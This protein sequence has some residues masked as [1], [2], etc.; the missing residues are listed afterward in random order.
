MRRRSRFDRYLSFPPV[1]TQALLDI[2]HIKKK[3]NILSIS[4]NGY[5][6]GV[7]Y[8]RLRD[9][10][11]PARELQEVGPTNVRTGPDPAKRDDLLYFS[12]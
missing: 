1:R 8:D 2:A 11:G 3:Y 6:T 10:L 9:E 5:Q 12:I 7:N 4:G